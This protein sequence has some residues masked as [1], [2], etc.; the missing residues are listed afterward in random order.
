MTLLSSAIQTILYVIFTASLIN[1]DASAQ[2]PK[3][4]IQVKEQTT[5]VKQDPNKLPVKILAIDK[6]M[7]SA[8]Y[9]PGKKEMGG[10]LLIHDCNSDKSVFDNIGRALGQLGIHA[11]AIDLRGYGEST[12]EKFSHTKLKSNAKNIVNYQ[13]DLVFL[14]SFW[15]KDV[16]SALVYLQ[17][18]I[19]HGKQ[20][21]VV[22]SGCS[23]PLAIN[24]AEQMHIAGLVMLSPKLDYM[25]RENYKNLNDIATFFI[26]AS[27]QRSSYKTTQELFTWNGASNSKLQIYKNNKSGLNLFRF[28]QALS[29]DITYWLQ[30]VIL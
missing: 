3:D 30:K 24:L 14:T 9:F 4:V 6:F 27:Q 1:A 2:S 10:V 19:A 15:P 25:E 7:L 18:K 29:N 28:D 11:L 26:D 22:S 12:D 20:I 5:F 13:N 16:L 23:A 21:A 17:E 8:D